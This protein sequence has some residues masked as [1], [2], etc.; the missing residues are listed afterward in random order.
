MNTPN[1]N[2]VPVN[3]G[4]IAGEKGMFSRYSIYLNKTDCPLSLMAPP[5]NVPRVLGRSRS[6]FYCMVG[7]VRNGKNKKYSVYQRMLDA[8]DEKIE[9]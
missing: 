4:H 1:S 6:S 9:S 8:P 2:F 3:K 7:R 5:T